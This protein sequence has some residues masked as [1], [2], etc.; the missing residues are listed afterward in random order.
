MKNFV[1]LF[2]MLTGTFNSCKKNDSKPPRPE[3]ARIVWMLGSWEGRDSNSV[4]FE[5][6]KQIKEEFLDGMAMV[7]IKGILFFQNE[8]R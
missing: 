8:S 5:D 6:W 2:L 4:Y 7:T 1:L 3:F